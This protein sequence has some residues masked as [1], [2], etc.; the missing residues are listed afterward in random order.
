MLISKSTVTYSYS[1]HGLAKIQANI[2]TVGDLLWTTLTEL[3][4]L[5]RPG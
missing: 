4:A 1:K 5:F 3:T 2:Q